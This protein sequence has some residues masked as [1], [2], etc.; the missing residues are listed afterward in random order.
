[1]QTHRVQY[2]SHSCL[3]NCYS[4]WLATENTKKEKTTNTHLEMEFYNLTASWFFKSAN[5]VW[6]NYKFMRRCFLLASQ[7]RAVT[8]V[9]WLVAIF[10]WILQIKEIASHFMSSLLLRYR[11]EFLISNQQIYDNWTSFVR[12]SDTSGKLPIPTTSLPALPLCTSGMNVYY[13]DNVRRWSSSWSLVE[14]HGGGRLGFRP[15]GIQQKD[16]GKRQGWTEPAAA[17]SR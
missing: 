17:K 14:W 8:F 6:D 5:P 11:N 3:L 15:F 13:D 4:G 12:G 1:M 2:Y 9:N 16:A 7:R 10:L